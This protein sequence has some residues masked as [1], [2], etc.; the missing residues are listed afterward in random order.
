MIQ[1][2]ITDGLVSAATYLLVALGFALVYSTARFFNFAHGVLFVLAPYVMLGMLRSLG[3]PLYVAAIVGVSA[4][5]AVGCLFD[6]ATY[7]PLRKR[8]LRGAPGEGAECPACV[9]SLGPHPA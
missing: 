3:M 1:Q 4:S 2:A 5:L 6:F 9:L 8:G 7:R